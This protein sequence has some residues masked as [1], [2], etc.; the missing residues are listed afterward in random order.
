[1]SR[2]KGSKNVEYEVAEEIPASCPTCGSTKLLVVPGKPPLVH[3]YAGEKPYDEVIWRDKECE[4]GQRVR[5]RGYRK[6]T[7]GNSKTAEASV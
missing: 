5:V 6:T 1:M 2:P 7:S 4:C 3:P